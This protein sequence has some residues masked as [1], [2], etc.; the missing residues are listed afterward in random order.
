M[1]PFSST[2]AQKT[3]GDLGFSAPQG[4]AA[5]RQKI[6]MG[7]AFGFMTDKQKWTYMELDEEYVP[8]FRSVMAPFMLEPRAARQDDAGYTLAIKAPCGRGKSWVFREYMKMVIAE[9]PNARILLL[10]ANIMYGTNLAHE[11]QTEGFDVGFYRDCAG[12]DK[13]ASLS[14]RQVVVCSFESLHHLDGQRFDVIL[15]DEIRH[16]SALPGGA[17]ANFNFGNLFLLRE[18]WATTPRR[19]ICDADLLYK[20]SDTEPCSAVQSLMA[21]LDNGPVLCAKLTHPGPPHLERSARIFYT[22]KKASR[23][24]KE[25]FN[26]IVSAA[27]AWHGNQDHRFAVCVGSK[28]QRLEVSNLLSELRVPFKPYDGDTRKDSK[29]DLKDPDTAWVVFGAIVATTTLS[30]GVDPKT[31]Q[32]ARVFIWTCHSGCGVLSQFQG[33]LRFGRSEGA[34]LLNTTIDILLDTKPPAVRA[35]E[36]REKKKPPTVLPTYNDA[37]K[38][39]I[40]QRAT[41]LR[42]EMRGYEVLGG[43]VGGVRATEPVCDKVLRLLAHRR[44]ERDLQSMDVHAAVVRACEE[45]GW[46]LDDSCADFDPTTFDASTLPDIDMDEDDAFVALSTTA[47]KMQWLVGHVQQ[48]GEEGFFRDC[49]QLTSV[50]AEQTESVVNLGREQVMAKGFWLLKHVQRL[51]EPEELELMAKSGVLGGLELNALTRCITAATQMERDR[52]RS[53]DPEKKTPHPFLKLGKGLRMEAAQDCA[54]LLGVD[55]L[56]QA[57]ELPQRVVE[58]SNREK[59]GVAE[60]GDAAFIASVRQYAGTLHAGSAGK[61]TT[62]LTNIAKACGMTLDVTRDKVQVDNVRRH[63]TT[64]MALTRLL[65]SIVDDWLVWSERLGAHVRVADWQE[66]HAE[67]D[68]EEQAMAMRREMCVYDDEPNEP[69][70]PAP[71]IAFEDIVSG[72]SCP[73]NTRFEKIDGQALAD[74]LDRLRTMP[75]RNARDDRWLAWLKAADESALPNPKQPKNTPVPAVRY[76]VVTYAKRRSIGRRTASHPSMQHCPSGLR[77]LLIM[78]FYHDVDIVSCHPTLMLQVALNMGV[79]RAKLERLHEYVNGQRAATLEDIAAFYGVHAKVCKYGV[80]RV[81]NGGSWEAWVKDAKCTQNADQPHPYLLELADVCKLVRD[82]F[83]R[84]DEFKYRITA[85]E[86]ELRAC[87]DAKVNQAEARLAAATTAKARDEA[88]LALWKA[89][90]KA[91]PPAVARSVFSHCIFELENAV[92]AT[93]D[94]HFKD[95]G[96]TVAS[97]IFDGVHVEHRVDACLTDAIRGAEERVRMELGYAIKLAEKPLS[98]LGLVADNHARAALDEMA[99]AEIQW[100]ADMEG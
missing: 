68:E 21:I 50:D 92:L 6:F 72:M 70:A 83:S 85:L 45:H 25:W 100:H 9:Q 43:A 76:L 15:I 77:P 22:Y 82:A 73:H 10:S 71:P 80:L 5:K 2:D 36:V 55:S 53:L 49:Y 81:L 24:K 97:L 37:L 32:F 88:K 57:G 34:P 60:G 91:T 58:V 54:D 23:S 26:E 4:G 56:F 29:D 27:Q 51:V 96:W 65:P 79:P 52:G 3:L 46:T 41:R 87:A 59:H 14:K 44:L 30:I 99:E 35:W 18:L 47:E 94:A 78:N 98:W 31:I 7:R 93:I 33:A 11:L 19:V 89:R 17:T 16:I 8:K 86:G 74:E 12:S 75:R 63:H 61:L 69:T 28:A 39:L 13:G 42:V 64:E 95:N 66:K 84:M 38:R 40:D 48:H 1:A 67:L 20:V 90:A 62:V